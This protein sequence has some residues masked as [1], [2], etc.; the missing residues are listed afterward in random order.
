[1]RSQLRREQ[2]RRCVVRVSQP[3]ERLIEL[4]AAEQRTAGVGRSAGK[5]QRAEEDGLDLDEREMAADGLGAD[6]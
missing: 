4:A 3:E 6:A 1:M 2:L 5:L